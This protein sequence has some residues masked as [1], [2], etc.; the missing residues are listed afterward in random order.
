M[1]AGAHGRLVRARS[2][3]ALKGSLS[4]VRFFVDGKPPRD[5]RERYTKAIRLRATKPLDPDED[6]LERSGWA[7]VGDPFDVDLGYENVF[8][9]EY[10][11]LA[12][13]TD[14]WL[15]PGSLLRASLRDAE[16]QALGRTKDRARLSRK[17][18]REL[19][20]FVAKKLRRKIPPVTRAVDLS[21]SLDEGLVRFFSHSERSITAMCDLFERTFDLELVSEA[22]YT[23]GARVGLSKQ[24]ELAWEALD[25]T[26]LVA[27]E[28]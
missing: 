19:K 2:V 23:L 13:R 28:E 12:F 6:I 15:L 26:V 18:K 16:A 22:P 3:S 9:D 21:W 20:E 11:N 14:K 8:Y 7:A 5:F 10:L 25:A 1:L 17:E 4:Y 27:E 24:E